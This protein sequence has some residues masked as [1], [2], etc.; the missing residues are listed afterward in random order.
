MDHVRQRLGI[1]RSN[2]VQVRIVRTVAIGVIMIA[3]ADD[4]GVVSCAE[5][6]IQLSVLI[7][8]VLVDSFDCNCVSCSQ[9]RTAIN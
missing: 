5:Q 1:Q 4:V 7:P 8:R 6:Q 2:Y 3:D 9:I